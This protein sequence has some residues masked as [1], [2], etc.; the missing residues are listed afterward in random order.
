MATI[1]EPNHLSGLFEKKSPMKIGL[2]YFT[3]Y[4]WRLIELIISINFNATV[5]EPP[6]DMFCHV[7]IIHMHI[8]KHVHI[9]FR[10]K[11]R[12]DFES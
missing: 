12:L 3:E 5:Y 4:I 6:R 11:I 7:C 10:P 1:S 2:Y 8:Y 9:K